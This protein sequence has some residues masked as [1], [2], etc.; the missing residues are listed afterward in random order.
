MVW[1]DGTDIDS[2]LLT[3]K[4][5]RG[6]SSRFYLPSFTSALVL[7]ELKM[8][9]KCLAPSSLRRY[10][11]R[12]GGQ[13][14][15]CKVNAEKA[16]PAQ[17]L[18]Y[19]LPSAKTPSMEGD[20][21]AEVRREAAK[22]RAATYSHVTTISP[23]PACCP[24]SGTNAAIKSE[25]AINQDRKRRRRRGWCSEKITRLYHQERTAMKIWMA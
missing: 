18:K 1:V 11:S 4:E 6:K 8:A 14:I 9:R 15:P 20:L 7:M 2:P 24:S 12:S 13:R 21:D 17:A 10:S 5:F 25:P 16:T 22:L 3:Q 23:V 19:W